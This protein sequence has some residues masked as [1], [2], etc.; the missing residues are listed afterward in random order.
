MAG[1]YQ[2]DWSAPG[3]RLRELPSIPG[4][5]S[6]IFGS[7]KFKIQISTVVRAR[8]DQPDTALVS[9]MGKVRLREGNPLP[10]GHTGKQVRT[11]TEGEL[12][13]AV[14][15]SHCPAL[16]EEFTLFRPIWPIA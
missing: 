16:Q 1:F 3:A 7:N 6:F 9:H 15:A 13:G 11:G 14:F 8:G 2:S 10:Q 5:D 12:L 4:V